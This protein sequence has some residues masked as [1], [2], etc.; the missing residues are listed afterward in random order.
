MKL[1][2]GLG[3][4]GKKYEK[5]RHNVGFMVLDILRE[6]LS[7]QYQMSE[8][9]VSKKFNALICG[10]TINNTK[11]LLAKPITFMNASGQSIA[12]IGQ[13]YRLV[14]ENMIVV[15]DEK[16]LP[17]GDIRVQKDRGHA[18]HNGIRS[19]MEQIGSKEFT[20]VRCGIASDDPKKMKDTAT[21]VLKKFS[22]LEKKKLKE[23][24]HNAAE[25]VFTEIQK[26]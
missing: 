22:L 3:N 7:Q 13:F 18:G 19:I 15:H 20:R 21:F 25:S 16:D 10:G 17:L 8:W 6:R 9:C 12:L 26:K 14:P 11:I 23:M 5:T 2:I 24:L 4:P 1:I